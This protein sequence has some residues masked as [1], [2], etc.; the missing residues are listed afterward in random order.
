MLRVL[1]W[2]L[3]WRHGEFERRH[4]AI[5]AVLRAE[6]ADA[7]CLQEVWANE[8][9]S[10]QGRQLA[11]ALGMHL[12]ST[13][14]PFFRGWSVNNVV[15]SKHPIVATEVVALPA[16]DGTPSHRRAVLAV[17]DT[18]WGHWPFVSTHTEHRFDRS[19]T[20]QAQTR[21]LAEAAAR[22][23]GDPATDAPLVIG[24]DLNAVPDSNEIRM[25]TGRAPPPVPGLVFTDAWEVRGDG[26][27][28]T[29]HAANPYL[30]DAAWP[31]RRLDYMLVSWPRPKP[32]G[33]PARVW[34]AG[35]APVDGV[36][37]SD[38]Y[39]VVVDLRVPDDDPGPG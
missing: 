9:G 20:R 29:W 1:T 39:A 35:T 4:A 32:F 13:E 33:H 28:H 11:E 18:P 6:A 12:A 21:A 25:L 30:A 16:V 7:C 3:W 5:E 26:P 24:G 36:M 34:L 14:G 15:L 23:R 38:H 10:H 2:N 8:D 22:W 27:G 31:N 19:T 17:L 37:P